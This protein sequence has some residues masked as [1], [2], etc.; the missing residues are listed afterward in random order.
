MQGGRR[1]V[2]LATAH[3]FLWLF[4]AILGPIKIQTP[5]GLEHILTVPLFILTF[6]QV[7]LLAIWAVFSPSGPWSRLLGLLIGTACLEAAFDRALGLE[8]VLMPSAA[9]VLT[10]V[11][12]IVV[13][14][15]GV[16]LSLRVDGA[17]PSRQKPQ[18]FRFSIRG[19]MVLTA[20][21]ALVTA[22]ARGLRQPPGH[23]SILISGLWSVCFAAVSFLTLWAA[24]GLGGL[25]RRGL[26]TVAVSVGLGA[27][28]AYV[29]DANRDGWVYVFLIM[30]LDP[31]VLLGS[32][33]F[34]RSCGYHLERRSVPR[35]SPSGFTS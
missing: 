19:L 2:L 31:V 32:L 29:A 6:S 28:I 34:V 14:S 4:S 26:L 20:V 17:E 25:L 10:V 7:S 8:F 11:S 23:F 18:E 12:M 35:L 3:L 1:L 5:F 30:L 22:L 16:R 9:M 33:R 13:W 15:F 24:C 21:V 27:F